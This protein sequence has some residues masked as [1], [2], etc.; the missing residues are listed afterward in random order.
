[1]RCEGSGGGGKRGARGNRRGAQAAAFFLASPQRE[2]LGRVGWSQAEGT[3]NERQES[4]PWAEPAAPPP[5]R[6]RL[7]GVGAERRELRKSGRRES[8]ESS[9]WCERCSLA[10]A[11]YSSCV[12]AAR[13]VAE[14]RPRASGNRRVAR[15]VGRPAHRRAHRFEPERSRRFPAQ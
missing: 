2:K 3:S 13:G 7:G 5:N 12:V 4:Q 10:G 6:G 11:R 14:G 1:M 15:P 8:P 9:S